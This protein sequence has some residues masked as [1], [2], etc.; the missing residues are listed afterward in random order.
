MVSRTLLLPA[1][2]LMLFSTGI[3]G[4]AGDTPRSMVGVPSGG[5]PQAVGQLRQ[6]VSDIH[7][8][9]EQTERS[10]QEL[11]AQRARLESE[12]AAL[13]RSVEQKGVIAG[14]L[15]SRISDA[16][17]RT[18]GGGAATDGSLAQAPLAQP[19]AGVSR[20]N[21]APDQWVLAVVVVCGLLLLGVLSRLLGGKRATVAKPVTVV[22]QD[23]SWKA[24]PEIG[25]A[26]ADVAPSLMMADIYLGYHR[27]SEAAAMIQKMIATHPGRHSLSVKLLEIYARQ[28][29]PARFSSYLDEVH[30][31]IQ[32]EAPGLWGRVVTM[33]RELLPRHPLFTVDQAPVVSQ[34]DASTLKKMVDF[35]HIEVDPELDI[36]LN[37]VEFRPGAESPPDR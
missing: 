27:Y 35:R 29:D 8:Y 28:G 17:R 26:E 30:V 32:T 24:A 2:L 20:W 16:Q 22:K 9:L 23:E 10:N 4:A 18:G 25:Q 19:T 12:L 7:Q 33:G 37:S 5:D 3:S 13:R 11:E 14:Q 15:Q 34:H 36:E 1:C 6:R 31:Q 21:L